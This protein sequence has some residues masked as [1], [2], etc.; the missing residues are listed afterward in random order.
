MNAAV[1]SGAVIVWSS[2]V[3]LLQREAGRGLLV[4][5]VAVGV[6]EGRDVHARHQRCRSRSGTWCRRWSWRRR[7]RC[8]RGSRRGRRRRWAGRWPGG[9]G[10]AP[11][12]RP[13]CRSSRRTDC[14]GP[15]AAPRPACS[16]SFRSGWCMTVVYWPWMSVPTCSWAAATTLRVAVAGAGDA[17]AGGEV[18]IAAAVGPVEVDALAAVGHHGCGL[19]KMRRQCG[20][21]RL[22]A[23]CRM[24]LG[25]FSCFSLGVFS[26]S[27]EPDRHNV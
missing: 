16:I 3:E 25:R 20:H 17:D 13:R 22:P 2:V 27:R 4:P 1:S 9:P 5:A 12:R 6:R 26:I 23:L 11:P 21:V 19:A 24:S 14:R 18:E 15:S 10:A 7:R 8:G